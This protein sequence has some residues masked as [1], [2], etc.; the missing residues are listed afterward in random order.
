MLEWHSRAFLRDRR[1]KGSTGR[2]NTPKSTY[3]GLGGVCD[4]IIVGQKETHLAVLQE[5][6]IVLDIFVGLVL[7]LDDEDAVELSSR[8]SK[9]CMALIGVGAGIGHE[10]QSL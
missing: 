4:G 8:H 3:V 10:S 2:S 1:Q 5:V 9:T 6:G 7:E